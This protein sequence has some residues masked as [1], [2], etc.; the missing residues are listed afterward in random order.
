MMSEL[1]VSG[2][3][4]PLSRVVFGTAQLRDSAH[5]RRLLDHAYDGGCRTF[6]TA[7]IYLFGEAE[8]SLGKWLRERKLCDEVTVITKCGHPSHRSRLTYA[9]LLADVDKSRSSLGQDC[10]DL[11]LVHRDDPALAAGEV[12]MALNKLRDLG[13][14]HA[15]GASNWSVPRLK[16][17]QAYA[18]SQKITSFSISSVHFSLAAWNQAP[19]P[20]CRT[21][22]G[23]AGITER[24][25]Y[26]TTNFPLLAWSSL[27]SGFF[28]EAPAGDDL[29]EG[30]LPLNPHTAATYLSSENIER[31]SRA[32]WLA[33]RK[34]V[35]VTR[36]VLAYVLNQPM[37]I[38]AI[39]GTSSKSHFIEDW[40]AK[41]VLLSESELRWLNLEIGELPNDL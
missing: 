36:V 38:G 11:L 34:G 41:D 17:A 14:V 18:D 30:S 6:D 31:R 8:T 21:V 27:S 9:D 3:Q 32:L 40:N 7:R 4:K 15:F 33:R 26:A 2:F 5:H 13:K 10:L 24:D 25:W 23:T 19:W 28:C 22:T 35:A 29:A 39:V 20:G 1:N 16:A 37:N 12:I